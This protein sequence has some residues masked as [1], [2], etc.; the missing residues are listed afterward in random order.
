[1]IVLYGV[2]LDPRSRGERERDHGLV[3]FMCT[4]NHK[5]VESIENSL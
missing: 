4:I 3:M 2:R 1:M 5:A